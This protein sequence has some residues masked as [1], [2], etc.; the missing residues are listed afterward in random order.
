MKTTI[1]IKGYQIVIDE[2]EEMVTVTAMKD[3]ETVEEFSLD[4]GEEAQGEEAQGE[5]GI[6]SFDDFGG[7][8]EDFGGEESQD[9]DNE[10]QDEEE[11]EEDEDDNEGRALESFQ[12]FINKKK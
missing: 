9:D 7:E 12:S 2:T 11:D 3:D 4:L 1:E 10:S 8:E 5:E 6:R